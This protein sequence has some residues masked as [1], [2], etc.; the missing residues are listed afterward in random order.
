MRG[1]IRGATL[2]LL[3]TRHDLAGKGPSFVLGNV[4]AEIFLTLETEANKAITEVQSE[5][6]KS[7]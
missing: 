3:I 4:G 5:L 1:L 7:G 6:I 2:L